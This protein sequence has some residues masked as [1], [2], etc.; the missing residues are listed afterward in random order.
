MLT[1]KVREFI[2]K[3]NGNVFVGPLTVDVVL[4]SKNREISTVSFQHHLELETAAPDLYAEMIKSDAGEEPKS[5]VER[6]NM[7]GVDKNKWTIAYT[8]GKDDI[9]IIKA[10]VDLNMPTF[11]KPESKGDTTHY[12]PELDLPTLLRMDKATTKSVERYALNCVGAFAGTRLDDNPKDWSFAAS[13]THILF[14]Y[15][16]HMD[17]MGERGN[18]NP[19]VMFPSHAIKNMSKVDKLEKG[20]TWTVCKKDGHTVATKVS[21]NI[22]VSVSWAVTPQNWPMLRQVIHNED[23]IKLDSTNDR[24]MGFRMTATKKTFDKALELSKTL[25]QEAPVI[26]IDNIS[27]D[28]TLLN[29]SA[30][31]HIPVGKVW[32][33]RQRGEFTP[34]YMNPEYLQMLVEHGDIWDVFIKDQ[35]PEFPGPIVFRNVSL[36]AVIMPVNPKQ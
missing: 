19:Q 35:D 7:L 21:K 36:Y 17:F 4:Q 30:I 33:T 20:G 22:I 8:T 2:S 18:H 5:G 29:G 11:R 34:L 9:E 31:D 27:G 16:D 6:A 10:S 32:L 3:A 26:R 12:V 24:R 15:G 28:I 25:K 1:L 14:M 13:N 23:T